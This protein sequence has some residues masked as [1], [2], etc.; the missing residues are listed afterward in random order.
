MSTPLLSIC[1]PAYNRPEFLKDLLKSIVKEDFSDY[2]IIVSE[3]NSPKTDEIEK[4]VEEFQKLYLDIPIKFFRNETT[5]GYDGN[6][7]TT[8]NRSSGEFCVFMGDDD[9]IANG[10]LAKIAQKIKDNKENNIGVILRSWARANRLTDEIVEYHHYFDT[11]RFFN[12][13]TESAVTLFKRS[14]AIAGYTVN[15]KLAIKF[16]T[17][18]FDGSLLYQLYLTGTILSEANAYYISDVIAIMRKDIDQKPTHFFGTAKS[19]KQKFNPQVLDPQNSINFMKGMFEIAEYLESEFSMKGML[20]K[21]QK[22]IGNYSFPILSLHADK[23][24]KTMLSYYVILGKMGL[25]KSPY[26]HIYFFSII[27]I[28]KKN[29][30]RIIS[31]LKKINKSTPL[32]GKVY[33]GEKI[34]K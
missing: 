17:D 1:I 18:I 33:S 21:T 16:Q 34:I 20:M 24:I 15:R 29:C 12:K 11:D 13:G 23:G 22:D 2:E 3:D 32:L 31:Y 26:F 8:I 7:R 5:L 6:F 9:L 4:I 19:E 25:S 28:G 14:V 27:F 10:A 30:E